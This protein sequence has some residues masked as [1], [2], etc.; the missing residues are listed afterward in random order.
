MKIRRFPGSEPPY[1][2]YGERS[3]VFFPGCREHT[4]SKDMSEVRHM[5]DVQGC[6]FNIQFYSVHDGPG[7]RTVVFLKGCPLRCA[8]CSNPESQNVFPEP[9]YNESKCL[10]CHRCLAACPAGARSPAEDGS[11]IRDAHLC[12]PRKCSADGNFPCAKA[13]PGK[14]MFSYGRFVRVEEVMQ[15]VEKDGAIYSR[16]GGGITLS[17]GEALMQPEFSAALLATARSRGV[18]TAMETSACAPE[19]VMREICS[20]L[21]YLIVDIKLADDAGHVAWTGVHNGRILA[22]I[23]MARREFPSLP[24]KVRTPLIPGVNDTEENIVNTVRI[25]RDFHKVEYELLPY[26]ALGEQKYT[27]LGREYGMGDV[28]ADYDKVK[29]LQ[30]MVDEMLGQ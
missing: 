10:H 16:S 2:H 11:I 12:D 14:A 1:F 15:E 28:L 21:D 30:H 7:I 4:A 26:H 13:C 5:K 25:I 18:H 9:G 23:A 17:G 27:Y 3:A 22:N 20:L 8:W 6:I 19:N 24:I 29:A